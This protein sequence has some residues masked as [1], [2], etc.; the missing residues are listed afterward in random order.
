LSAGR[1]MQLQDSITFAHGQKL[2]P[3]RDPSCTSDAIYAR[4]RTRTRDSTKLCSSDYLFLHV[5]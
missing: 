5:D 2:Y 3:K 4:A 1:D